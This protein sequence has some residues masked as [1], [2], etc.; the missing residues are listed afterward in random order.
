[1]KDSGKD[2]PPSQV[3]C[4]LKEI[5]GENDKLLGSGTEEPV[6]YKDIVFGNREYRLFLVA[7]LLGEAGE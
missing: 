1:M 2:N 7:W 6:T 5:A 3:G 4:G